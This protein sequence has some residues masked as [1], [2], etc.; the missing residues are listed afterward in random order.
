MADAAERVEAWR[1]A[2][3][4]AG[5]RPVM[6]WFPI[7]FKSELDALA[8]A[9]GQDP[10]A[11]VMD[12][13][14][15]FAAGQ[16]TRKPLRLDPQQVHLLKDEITAYVLAQ[17]TAAG[18]TLP[19][20]AL[21]EPPPARPKRPKTGGKLGIPPETLQA[22]CAER[23]KYPD[24]S[25]LKL[26]Q[27][28]YDTGIYRSTSQHGEIKPVNPGSLKVWLDNAKARGLLESSSSPGPA[29]GS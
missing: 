9:R 27:H 5:Y 21:P 1:R 29:G 10:A 22:I 3:R 17:V 2:K 19:A 14:H 7:D 12:A 16:G 23:R 15:A 6:L 25:L 20:P 8:Y 26:S 28:L 11:Y 13:V 24:L 18:P 4:Q